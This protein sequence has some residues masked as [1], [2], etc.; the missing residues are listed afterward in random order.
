[1]NLERKNAKFPWI[2]RMFI[3]AKGS[4]FGKWLRSEVPLPAYDPSSFPKRI[5]IFWDKGE[6]KA[7]EIV[8]H[9]IESWRGKNLD[10][11]VTVLDA[12]A[13]K[14]FVDPDSLPP[15]IRIA[16]YA[17][18]LRMKILSEHGGIWVDATCMCL[19]PLSSWIFP[20]LSQSGFFVFSRPGP[21]RLISNWFIASSADSP[22][23]SKWSAVSERYWRLQ[24]RKY[25]PYFWV[26]YL[27]EALTRWDPDVRRL[28][29][30]MPKVSAVPSLLVTRS[31]VEGGQSSTNVRLAKAAYIQKLSYKGK[32]S[33]QDVQRVLS[34]LEEE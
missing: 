5:Y 22:I 31:L 25:P 28:W 33:W 21:D 26:H 17:D 20:L 30:K 27:F 3:R 19:K 12:D 7:P 14:N 16:H 8:K 15:E 9:C 10:W 13:A 23:I 32:F 1:M 24:H 11:T 2:F 29:R 18:L 6:S 34:S 4:R